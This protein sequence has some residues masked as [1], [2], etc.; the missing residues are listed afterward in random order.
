MA[1]AVAALPQEM[2]ALIARLGYNPH[3]TVII[4]Q[5]GYDA[6]EVFGELVAEK[7][8]SM[9]RTLS[10]R[11]YLAVQNVADITFPVQTS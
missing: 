4:V 1:A 7:V 11:T 2:G 9:M 3:M 8:D 10:R 5:E 6:V